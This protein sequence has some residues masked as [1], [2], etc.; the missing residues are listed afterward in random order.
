MTEFTLSNCPKLVFAI[1]IF[2]GLLTA[3]LVVGLFTIGV[4]LS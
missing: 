2:G 3:G 4:A 1:V